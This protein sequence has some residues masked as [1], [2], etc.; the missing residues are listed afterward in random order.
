MSELLGLSSDAHVRKAIYKAIS[1]PCTYHLKS[2]LPVLFYASPYDVEHY[3]D[4]LNEAIEIP[5]SQRELIVYALL[6]MQD[7]FPE[8]K[9]TSFKHLSFFE[10]GRYLV[11]FHFKNS[12]ECDKY[13]SV[14]LDEFRMQIQKYENAENHIYYTIVTSLLAAVFIAFFSR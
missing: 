8:I 12:K 2:Q 5:W 13:V 11:C 7:E 6:A 4:E 10:S 14:D 9:T 3:I 1:F